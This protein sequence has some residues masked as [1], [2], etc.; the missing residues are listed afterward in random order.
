MSL[1]KKINYSMYILLKFKIFMVRFPIVIQNV[2]GI[3][4]MHPHKISFR[5]G[6]L[7]FAV[8]LLHVHVYLYV[9]NRH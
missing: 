9:L 1:D 6:M 8:P 2:G 5:E 7:R 3:V 4:I